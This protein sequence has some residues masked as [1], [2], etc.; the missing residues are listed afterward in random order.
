M[1]PW[2]ILCVHKQYDRYLVGL[3][4]QDTVLSLFIQLSSL[5]LLVAEGGHL[6]HT[7]LSPSLVHSH[8]HAQLSSLQQKKLGGR[9]KRGWERGFLSTLVTMST[10][11]CGSILAVSFGERERKLH[12]APAG[13][14]TL[15]VPIT[16]WTLLPLRHWTHSRGV[17]TTAMLEAS[18]NS[19]CLSL[20]LSQM[21]CNYFKTSYKTKYECLH[22]I[23]NG[24]T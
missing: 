3:S 24:Y 7:L 21:F 17:L 12:R 11:G 1:F 20:S 15:E 18:A 19:S 14:Q 2:Q 6:T 9:G 13:N 10:L 23:L 5:S 22:F 16:S 8:S 4:K